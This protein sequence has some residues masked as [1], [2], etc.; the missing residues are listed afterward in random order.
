MSAP[1][2]YLPQVIARLSDARLA[3]VGKELRRRTAEIQGYLTF[4]LGY[5]ATHAQDGIFRAGAAGHTAED[6]FESA[7]GWSGRASLAATLKAHGLLLAVDGGVKL[8]WWDEDQAPKVAALER[9]RARKA[10]GRAGKKRGAPKEGPRPVRAPSPDAPGTVRAKEKESEEEREEDKQQQQ[11][12][13]APVVALQTPSPTAGQSKDAPP[14]VQGTPTEPARTLPGQ[15]AD[16]PRPALALVPP[17]A[18]TQK[19]A[20]TPRKPRNADLSPVEAAVFD[21]WRETWQLG[22]LWVMNK[23]RREVIAARLA[24]RKQDGTPTFTPGDLVDAVRGSRLDTWEKRP[25]NIDLKQLLKSSNVARFADWHRK[26]AKTS[27]AARP[28]PACAACGAPAGAGSVWG[29]ELC[30][31]HAREAT[32]DEATGSKGWLERRGLL[33]PTAPPGPLP[34][35]PGKPPAD[36]S[37]PRSTHTQAVHLEQA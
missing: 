5:C 10:E 7:V 36:P 4:A 33:R 34:P 3:I 2:P 15:S 28:A 31:A 13:G 1:Y 35:L 19:P 21:S 22:P 27:G 9:E 24:E 6:V 17:D 26:H 16:A 20:K 8:A 14:P 12:A 25:E 29:V 11:G 37:M 23:E 32:A 30:D 18:A